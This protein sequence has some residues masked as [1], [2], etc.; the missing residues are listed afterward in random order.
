MLTVSPSLFSLCGQR[1]GAHYLG[2]FVD[3]DALCCSFSIPTFVELEQIKVKLC[4]NLLVSYR[5]SNWIDLQVLSVCMN[6][7]AAVGDVL[8]AG[9]LCT[10]LHNSR[11]SFSRSNTL[12]NKL[13]RT[14]N[15]L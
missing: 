6:V 15:V 13:V 14:R 9:I 5:H 8:I 4:I 11:T 3:A 10:I 1:V 7:F 2:R 12:I